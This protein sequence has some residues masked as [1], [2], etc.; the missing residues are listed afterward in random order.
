M[1]TASN[2]NKRLFHRM[3]TWQWSP[4]WL[5]RA[6][7]GGSPDRRRR[8]TKT[9][10]Q[11]TFPLFKKKN[12]RLC[13]R[14]HTTLPTNKGSIVGHE[15]SILYGDGIHLGRRELILLRRDLIESVAI[16]NSKRRA[17]FPSFHKEEIRLRP[18]MHTASNTNQTL[19]KA[20]SSS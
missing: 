2:A 10:Q 12:T 19:S 13:P 14:I 18:R 6:C 11:A 17:T 1:H 8:N 9:R 20:S 4:S 15:V 3:E 7:L 16:S 5:A